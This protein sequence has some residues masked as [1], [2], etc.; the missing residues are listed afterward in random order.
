M[1][2]RLETGLILGG[3]LTVLA[4]VGL[5]S[6]DN[7]TRMAKMQK[8]LNAEVLAQPFRVAEPTKRPVAT[9]PT[10]KPQSSKRYHRSYVYPRLSLGW[11]YGYHSHGFGLHYGH[12]FHRYGLH[13]KHRFHRYHRH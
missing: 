1:R 2:P 7:A 4:S 11:H 5:A 3:L 9:A 12:R 8:S 6:A 13:K 10:P